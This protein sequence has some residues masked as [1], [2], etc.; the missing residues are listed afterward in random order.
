MVYHMVRV[1]TTPFAL[2]QTEAAVSKTTARPT[3]WER[4]QEF[5][6]RLPMGGNQVHNTVNIAQQ[7][8]IMAWEK[9]NGI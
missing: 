4:R 2:K 3:R 7:G 8:A 5:S 1:G 9:C 6:S